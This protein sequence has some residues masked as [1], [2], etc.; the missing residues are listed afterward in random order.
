MS[1]H[2]IISGIFTGELCWEK[3]A[4]RDGSCSY[5]SASRCGGNHFFVRKAVLKGGKYL[6]T[7]K[8]TWLLF[9]ESQVLS[10]ALCLG[11]S[12]QNKIFQGKTN[13][14]SE[15]A[16]NLTN[17]LSQQKSLGKLLSGTNFPL[18]ASCLILCPEL[19]WPGDSQRNRGDS[20]RANRFVQINPH[21]KISILITFERFA[22]ITSTCDSQ[23]SSATKRDCQKGGFSSGT[24][25][26]FARIDWFMRI[27]K[28]IHANRAI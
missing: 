24:L 16:G 22:R 8:K 27:H 11:L 21:K 1:H 13:Q 2:V 14:R 25:R 18:Q 12:Y 6:E 20:C 3:I 10:P 17:I 9:R 26:R 5:Q 15:I 23:C 19:R 7:E 4:S 28:S